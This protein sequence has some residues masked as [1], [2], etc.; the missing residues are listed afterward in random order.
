M[1]TFY[2]QEILMRELMKYPPFTRMTTVLLKGPDPAAVD[3]AAL[4]VAARLRAMLPPTVELK[5][6]APAPLAKAKGLSR[7]HLL[8]FAPAARD[9]LPALR[10]IQARPGLPR[11][12]TLTV[13]VDAHSLM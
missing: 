5:G 2:D 8:L 7:V 1:D 6:P 3:V 4:S 10:A 9:Y 11:G 13:D 12:M